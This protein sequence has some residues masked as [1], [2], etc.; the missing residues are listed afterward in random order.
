MKAMKWWLVLAVFVFAIVGTV[1][2]RVSLNSMDMEGR[3]R[4]VAKLKAMGV[5]AW[6]I[7]TG[8]EDLYPGYGDPVPGHKRS[9][10]VRLVI[11]RDHSGSVSLADRAT[12][13]EMMVE[14]SRKVRDP[15]LLTFVEFGTN[16]YSFGTADGPI[17]REQML[18]AWQAFR[19]SVGW[20]YDP[21]R[22]AV[23]QDRPGDNQFTNFTGLFVAILGDGLRNITEAGDLVEVIVLTDGDHDPPYE[24]NKPSALLQNEAFLK[25]SISEHLA[26]VRS[27]YPDHLRVTVVEVGSA[28][29]SPG[30]VVAEILNGFGETKQAD[31]WADVAPVI[32]EIQ[33]RTQGTFA[34]SGADERIRVGIKLQDDPARIG[35]FLVTLN[36]PPSARF[37]TRLAVDDDV[38]DANHQLFGAVVV[39]GDE[40]NPVEFTGGVT[41]SS[42]DELTF[43][44]YENPGGGFGR[45]ILFPVRREYSIVLE[46]AGNLISLA[47]TISGAD[48]QAI[49]PY[50]LGWLFRNF[51]SRLVKLALLSLVLVVLLARRVRKARLSNEPQEREEESLEFNELEGTV[52]Y[53]GDNYQLAG[54]ACKVGDMH[55]LGCNGRVF[56]RPENDAVIKNGSGVEHRVVAGD[57]HA[58]PANHVTICDVMQHTTYEYHPKED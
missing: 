31:S 28:I 19:P 1:V 11:A 16:F 20:M 41:I 24:R 15:N 50:R 8:V 45:N 47:P 39:N 21:V 4:A 29:R 13:A 2:M 32:E 10:R 58:L 6:L 36:G 51:W 25:Q 18:V 44:L 42:G 7:P 9:G 35:P 30:S 12:T 57:R 17:Q 43:I 49:E 37:T 14:I 55:F 48:R 54:L 23:L 5:P 27:E 52:H 34:L 46:P 38:F 40:A 3:L 53:R 56:V 33:R 22:S 26:A